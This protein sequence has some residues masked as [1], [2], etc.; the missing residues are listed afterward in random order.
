MR[1]DVPFRL[2]GGAQPLAV[3][4]VRLNG[5]GPFQ[6]V[7]DTGASR[8]VLTPKLAHARPGD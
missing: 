5:T 2:L 1:Y 6:F 3:L 4:P 7:L 8:P